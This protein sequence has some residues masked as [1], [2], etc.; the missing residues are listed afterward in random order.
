[1]DDME[2]ETAEDFEIV[3]VNAVSSDKIVGTTPTSGASIDSNASTQN[4]TLP[5]S[6]YPYGLIEFSVLDDP[7][8]PDDPRIPP[9][10]TPPQVSQK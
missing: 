9:A 1:M 2:P 6:D 10:E 5:E 4:I 8:L 3:L 7:P